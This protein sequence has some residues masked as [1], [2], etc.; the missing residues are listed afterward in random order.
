M[1]SLKTEN[2]VICGEKAKYW[3]GHVKGLFKYALGYSDRKVVAGFCEKHKDYEIEDETGFYG[4]Y[5]S[6]KMGKCI[7]LFSK[8]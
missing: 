2:C 4:D 8:S 6:S 1:Q 7:S 5:D 3:H